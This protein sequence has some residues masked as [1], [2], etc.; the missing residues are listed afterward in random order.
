MN[1]QQNHNNSRG[2][3]E[4]FEESHE[5]LKSK[6]ANI[7][8]SHLDASSKRSSGHQN[9][10]KSM[11]STHKL[12]SSKR[13]NFSREIVIPSSQIQNNKRYL[14][15][16]FKLYSFKRIGTVTSSFPSTPQSVL[17]DNKRKNKER[18]K[19]KINIQ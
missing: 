7:S 3:D 13:N 15:I 10:N 17:G 1:I 19:I 8:V 18:S 9:L 16:N 2:L 14:L 11:I 4:A 6:F 12:L 5:K